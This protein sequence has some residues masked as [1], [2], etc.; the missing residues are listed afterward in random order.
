MCR[1]FKTFLSA[2]LSDCYVVSLALLY[3]MA[4]W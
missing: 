3:G 2:H 1:E 4:Y